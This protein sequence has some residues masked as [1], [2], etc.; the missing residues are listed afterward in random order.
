MASFSFMVMKNQAA[1]FM[2][3]F[4]IVILALVQGITEFLPVSSSG[5]L[6]LSHALLEGG[7]G[8]AW[9]EDLVLD[10]AVH[11]GSLI[12]VLLYFR[13]D[14]ITMLT[15]LAHLARGNKAE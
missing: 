15:G 7:T 10:L 3:L 6:L 9:Q 12:A 1:L 8:D 5:H 13:Q 2:S 11:V 4:H 14:V